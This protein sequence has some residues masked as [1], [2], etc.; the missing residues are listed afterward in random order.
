MQSVACAVAIAETVPSPRSGRFVVE[1]RFGRGVAGRC[2]RLSGDLGLPSPK[3]CLVVAA[4]GAEGSA[5]AT[6]L[7]AGRPVPIA[8]SSGDI[9]SVLSM[10][11]TR[12]TGDFPYVAGFIPLGRPVGREDSGASRKVAAPCSPSRE[13]VFRAEMRRFGTVTRAVVGT[14]TKNIRFYT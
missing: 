5:H 11:S 6:C 9:R 14:S 2:T 3:K 13:P 1:F 4:H 7:V 10:V 12:S 8:A